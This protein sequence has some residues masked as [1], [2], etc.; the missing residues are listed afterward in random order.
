MKRNLPNK[1]LP[2]KTLLQ[3]F[4]F[5]LTHLFQMHP[6]STSWKKSENHKI[7][8]CFKGVEKGCIGNKWVTKVWNFCLSIF[9]FV[10]IC[11]ALFINFMIEQPKSTRHCVKSIAIMQLNLSTSFRHWFRV[12]VHREININRLF[13]IM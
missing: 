12:R 11:Y 7:F 2:Y 10:F 9:I 5:L 13:V 6:F 3:H 8:W 1:T 4:N